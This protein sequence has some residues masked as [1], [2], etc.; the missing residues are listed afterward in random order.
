MQYL[1]HKSWRTSSTKQYNVYLNKWISYCETYSLNQLS[2]TVSDVLN[3]LAFLFDQGLGY[4]AINT[5]RSALSSTINF[6]ND[7]H[8]IGEHPL[9]QRFV[10]GVFQQRPSVPRYTSTW[11]VKVV[12]DYLKSISPAD[13]IELKLLTMKVITLCLLVTGS[14]CQTLQKMHL[15]YVTVGK[16]SIKCNIV[17]HVKHS[18]PGKTQPLLVLPAFPP[19]RRLCIFTYMKEYLQR[20]E[21]IRKDRNVFISFQKPHCKVSCA[22]IARWTKTVMSDAGIDVGKY[23]AHSTRAA[24][25]STAMNA[26]VPVDDI[27]RAAGWSNT[28]TFVKFY[29]KNVDNNEHFAHAIL[30]TAS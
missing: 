13:K 27:L 14:R 21:N 5:A 17:H 30:N 11:D 20:T 6:A 24:S 28:C 8:K 4:S 25:T 10:R 18:A 7:S 15:D 1:I 19:D 23:K 16:S 3:F 2:P 29:N 9:I 22:T 12:L 26:N